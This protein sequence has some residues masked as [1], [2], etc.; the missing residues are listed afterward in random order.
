MAKSEYKFIRNGNQDDQGLLKWYDV[1]HGYRFVGQ[2]Y[3]GDGRWYGKPW[4]AEAYPTRTPGR[5]PP[6]PLTTRRTPKTSSRH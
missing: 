4:M 6:R 2:V 5:R 3:G 1:Y